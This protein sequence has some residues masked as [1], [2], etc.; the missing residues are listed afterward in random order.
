MQIIKPIRLP[1]A[2][3][4][5]L[6]L[7]LKSVSMELMFLSV[8][9]AGMMQRLNWLAMPWETANLTIVCFI[10][11]YEQKKKLIHTLG[12]VALSGLTA[13]TSIGI[14]NVECPSNPISVSEC[15][16]TIPPQSP[17]CLS[18]FSAAGIRCIQ[19]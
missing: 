17:R 7:T 8:T 3:I 5:F 2:P 11:C 18:N 1:K 19:G 9:L 12:G 16:G 4:I 13:T 6:R 10:T 15:S 14:E